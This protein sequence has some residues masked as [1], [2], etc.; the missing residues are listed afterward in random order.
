LLI[1]KMLLYINVSK[2]LISKL[3]LRIYVTNW[4]RYKVDN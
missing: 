4:L 3:L 1:F 2:L